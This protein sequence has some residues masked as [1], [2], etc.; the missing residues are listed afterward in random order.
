MA[1]RPFDPRQRLSDSATDLSWSRDPIADAGQRTRECSKRQRVPWNT[2]PRVEAP[3]R[4]A[5]AR[6]SRAAVQH[7]QLLAQTKV[8]RN[9]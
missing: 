2:V 4:D 1:D 7:Q 5:Q 8:L 9:Q 3:I 6:P